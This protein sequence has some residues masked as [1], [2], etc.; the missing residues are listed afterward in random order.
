[1]S[2]LLVGAQNCAA[3]ESGAYTGE[4]SAAMLKEAG[5][6][7]VIVA[8]SERREYQQETDAMFV[9]KIDLV[10][11]VANAADLSLAELKRA[12]LEA[13]SPV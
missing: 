13:F 9:K 5:C 7:Y 3:E 8:H 4:V 10:H 12:A 1:M 2:P 6:R 11:R